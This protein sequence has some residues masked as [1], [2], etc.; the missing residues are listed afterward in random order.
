MRYNWLR[1]CIRLIITFFKNDE[2]SFQHTPQCAAIFQNAFWHGPFHIKHVAIFLNS[3]NLASRRTRSPGTTE[4]GRSHFHNN[5]SGSAFSKLIQ[6]QPLEWIRDGNVAL[7][8]PAN[9]KPRKKLGGAPEFREKMQR[10]MSAST[11][12]QGNARIIAASTWGNELLVVS[13]IFNAVVISKGK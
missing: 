10:E 8:P 2:Y 12:E 4:N 1:L 7:P 6:E 3:S 5:N 9:G 11:K 13:G